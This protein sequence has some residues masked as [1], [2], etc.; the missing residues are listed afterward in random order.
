ML[1]RSHHHYDHAILGRRLLDHV[2]DDGAAL[3]DVALGLHAPGPPAVITVPH[4]GPLLRPGV[5]AGEVHSLITV[6][7]HKKI[8][9]G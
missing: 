8:L 7:A 3:P 1:R 2:R 5:E 9:P 6:L 4:S